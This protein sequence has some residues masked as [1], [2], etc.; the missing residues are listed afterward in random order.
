M[1][2]LQRFVSGVILAIFTSALMTAPLT[3]VQEF[4]PVSTSFASIY[5]SSTGLMNCMPSIESGLNAYSVPSVILVLGI[6][7][8]CLC[9]LR[10]PMCKVRMNDRFRCS[11]K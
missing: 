8:V 11:L 4:W 9:S 2:L 5:F 1:K 3:F 7:L 10:F 6:V